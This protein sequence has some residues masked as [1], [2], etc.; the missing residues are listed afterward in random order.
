MARVYSHRFLSTGEGAAGSFTIPAGNT[1]VLRWVTVHNY[2]TTG[3][4]A[5]ALIDRTFAV[6]LISGQAR[7]QGTAVGPTTEQI[8]LR[9]VLPGGTRVETAND[10]TIDMT[11]SGYL[12]LS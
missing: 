12:F 2:S 4:A 1:G 6:Y 10:P 9:I 3:V 7:Q 11:V 8:E 5:Y